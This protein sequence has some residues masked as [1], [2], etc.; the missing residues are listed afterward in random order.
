VQ[1]D[2]RFAPGW[3]GLADC[4]GLLSN[5]SDTSPAESMMRAQAAAL[6]ALDLDATLAD[7][8]TS[9][10]L[11]KRDY[12]WDFD[13]AETSFQRAIE[14]TPNYATAWQW[15]AENFVRLKR[16]DEAI[17][18]MKQARARDPFSLIINSGLGWA[19]HQ[20]RRYAEA[21]EQLRRT[22]QLDPSFARTHFYL[23]RVHQQ[24]ERFEEAATATREALRLSGDETLFQASLAHILS[25]SGKRDEARRILLTLQQRGRRDYLSPFALAL[26]HIGLGETESAF[27]LIETAERQKDPI[28]VNYIRD[29]QLDPIRGDKRFA[30]LLQ[31][32]R[33]LP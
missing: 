33:L 21:E 4:Y 5:Y 27:A 13:A 10:G 32:L 2:D 17:D 30:A 12:D 23:G 18:A 26:I 3:A 22:I 31:R 9:L 7:A 14:L 1:A 29:P 24:Q 15:R 20:A 8:H 19:L 28:L 6:R 11:V 25:L 16:T